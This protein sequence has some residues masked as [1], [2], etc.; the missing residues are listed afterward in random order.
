MTLLYE[1]TFFKSTMVTVRTAPADIPIPSVESHESTNQLL[2]GNFRLNLDEDHTPSSSAPSNG[3]QGDPLRDSSQPSLSLAND[4]SRVRLATTPP[5]S[6]VNPG[7]RTPPRDP[8][9][10]TSLYSAT[11]R[12]TPVPDTRQVLSP[13]P[14]PT[15]ASV[16]DLHRVSDEDPPSD[17]AR[18]IDYERA[19]EKCR[20]VM[21]DIEVALRGSHLHI[22]QDSSIRMLYQLA[23]SLASFQYPLKRTVGFVG[24]SGV[25]KSSLLNSLLDAKDLARTVRPRCCQALS[26]ESLLMP[27][28]DRGAAAQRAH[29]LPRNIAT[30]RAQI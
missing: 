25:G 18:S 29:V 30:T 11:S 7:P 19:L 28:C 21:S 2:E 10:S 13:S 9:V 4:F 15:P 24:D 8:S 17:A 12:A 27:K 6:T 20:S 3:T 16:R 22:E 5:A 26:W 1:I 23:S 14:L